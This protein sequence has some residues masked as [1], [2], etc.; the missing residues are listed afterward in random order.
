MTTINRRTV[1]VLTDNGDT[2][3]FQYRNGTRDKLLL[4]TGYGTIGGGT[5]TLHRAEPDETDYVAVDTW[6]AA[7]AEVV[8]PASNGDYYLALTGA[9]APDLTLVINMSK[10]G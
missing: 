7:F 9:T 4:V 3:V 5:V 6:T 1:S 8:V 2:D 10:G